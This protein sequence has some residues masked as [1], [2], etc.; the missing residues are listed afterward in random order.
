MGISARTKLYAALFLYYILN[1]TVH[2][3]LVGKWLSVAL[4]S[5]VKFAGGPLLGKGYDLPWWQTAL[6]TFIGMMVTVILF[7]TI[8]RAFYDKY[9]KKLFVKRDEKR[10]TPG[11]R[12]LV[13][14]WKTFGISGIAFLTP[15]LLTPIGGSIVAAAFGEEPRK[16]IGY[17][18]VSG[19]FWAIIFSLG[20][21]FIPYNFQH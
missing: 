17:M 8:A 5:S 20:L 19:A 1:T 3:E 7:S 13:K 18:A 21:H 6:F 16:I 15:I 2:M 12:R 9:I 11:K 10:I 4:L 14:V